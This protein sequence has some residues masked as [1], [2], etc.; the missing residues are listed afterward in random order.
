MRTERET[1]SGRPAAARR[2]GAAFRLSIRSRQSAACP[3]GPQR[4]RVRNTVRRSRAAFTLVELMVV[5]AIIAILAGLLMPAIG[6]ALIKAHESST[7]NLIHQC[8][9]AATGFFN[10]HGAV[11]AL[12]V[13]RDVQH[14]Q[15]R[16]QCDGTSQSTSTMTDQIGW[17]TTP[18]SG[19]W[20]SSRNGRPH[21]QQPGHRGL[22]GL[23]CL[24]GTA[25]PTCSLGNSNWATRMAIRDDRAPATWP[26]RDQLVL[27]RQH[28]A[29]HGAGRLVGQSPRL[30]Q[31]PRLRRHDG[32]DSGLDATSHYKTAAAAHVVAGLFTRRQRL[33]D[34]HAAEPGLLTSSTASA[35]TARRTRPHGSW[36]GGGLN[37]DGI[38][39]SPWNH[40]P[41][42][43]TSWPTGSSQRMNRHLQ[44]ESD[45]PVRRGSSAAPRLAVGWTP[46][47]PSRE[48]EPPSPSSSCWS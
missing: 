47:A 22:P 38:P 34:R 26:S 7:Q 40:G 39:T 31:Q 48:S 44:T 41:E 6:G 25:A 30:H 16:R 12:D 37:G 3:P 18:T 13:A 21:A 9:I 32:H 14:A 5:I 2:S 23:R 17:R 15:L 4:R 33:Q 28:A 43:S 24:A 29:A 36:D 20:P 45:R 27:R 42:A 1:G 8:E 35:R 46:S 11:P 10:D 19:A